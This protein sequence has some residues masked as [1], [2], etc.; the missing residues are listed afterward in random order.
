MQS[1]W[2]G[3]VWLTPLWEK[4]R[5]SFFLTFWVFHIIALLVILSSLLLL[6]LNFGLFSA[7]QLDKSKRATL[8]VVLNI[9]LSA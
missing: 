9:F 4:K 5:L 1:V 2:S 6:S 7:G 3:P 8:G